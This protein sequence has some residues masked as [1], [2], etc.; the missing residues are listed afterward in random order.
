MDAFICELVAARWAGMSS[1]STRPSLPVPGTSSMFRLCS[2]RRPRTAGVARP[3]AFLDD[4]RCSSLGPDS[5]SCST[6][7]GTSVVLSTS[8][9]VS[10]DPEVVPA[11]PLS[12]V[13]SAS[14]AGVIS[15]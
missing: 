6:A 5:V 2:L 14:F 9:A 7:G 12:G 11:V 3:A 10:V 13:I 15:L 8:T 4:P 1:L